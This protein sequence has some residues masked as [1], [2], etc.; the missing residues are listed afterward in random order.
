MI[1]YFHYLVY[2]FESSFAIN[3]HHSFLR[4]RFNIVYRR[5]N[6]F[7]ILYTAI[8]SIQPSS[9]L[10]WTTIRYRRSSSYV[11]EFYTLE[12]HDYFRLPSTVCQYT[13]NTGCD[14]DLSSR[15]PRRLNCVPEKSNFNFLFGAQRGCEVAARGKIHGRCVRRL[16]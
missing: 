2:S 11:L 12:G 5:S 7:M 1:K 10:S 4:Q 13:K 15:F 9:L 8:F 3:H 14:S 16:S 6:T